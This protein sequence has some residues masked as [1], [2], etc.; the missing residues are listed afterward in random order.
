MI[1]TQIW[2]GSGLVPRHYFDDSIVN[3]NVLAPLG[4][5]LE[6]QEFPFEGKP[7]QATIEKDKILLHLALSN[8][9]LVYIDMDLTIKEPFIPPKDGRPWLAKAWDTSYLMV[10][11]AIDKIEQ[12]KKAY[13]AMTKRPYYGFLGDLFRAIDCGI[14]PPTTYKHRYHTYNKGNQK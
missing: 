8:P 1:Y 5:A 13:D 3:Y 7:E 4:H 10:N 11:G 14:I 9:E 2:V 6:M 12:V